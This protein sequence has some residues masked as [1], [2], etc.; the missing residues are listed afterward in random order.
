MELRPKIR[1]QR[2]R[3]LS[4]GWLPA[5]HSCLCCSQLYLRQHNLGGLRLH[6]GHAHT[7]TPPIHSK[8][9][10]ATFTE[11]AQALSCACERAEEIHSI[12]QRAPSLAVGETTILLTLSLHPH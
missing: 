8:L 9:A 7:G 6:D 4:T 3:C 10:S 5:D 1:W 12:V 2:L 11:V